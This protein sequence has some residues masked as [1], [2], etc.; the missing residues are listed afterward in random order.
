MTRPVPA[1]ASWSRPCQSYPGSSV[2]CGSTGKTDATTSRTT[3]RVVLPRQKE[4]LLLPEEKLT[5]EPY[6]M[7]VY[8]GDHGYAECCGCKAELEPEDVYCLLRVN[9]GNTF[10]AC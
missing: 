5:R 4:S 10:A 7:R 6:A 1:A 3:V 2:R 9:T 8:A